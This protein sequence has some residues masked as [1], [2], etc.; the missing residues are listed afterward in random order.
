MDFQIGQSVQHKQ[1]GDGVITG[2]LDKTH[3][4][5]KFTTEEFEKIISLKFLAG[6]V[7]V[8]DAIL[9]L[10][11]N[12][13]SVGFLEYLLEVKA[14]VDIRVHYPK[15][16]EPYVVELFSREGIELPADI[17]ALDSGSRGGTT[18]QR[19]L[20]GELW[21]PTPENTSLIPEPAKSLNGRT[22]ISSLAVILSVLKAG[23]PVT[24]YA[25]TKTVDSEV[26]SSVL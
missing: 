19:T 1:F 12:N 4:K 13:L 22:K 6:Y 17:R 14:L 16:A 2:L 25:A 9:A 20:A 23:F 18:V 3:V 8:G 5:A 11:P 26:A 21:F 7:S 10:C 15:H 24:K